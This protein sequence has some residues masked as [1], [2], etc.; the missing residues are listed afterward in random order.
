MYTN[1]ELEQ[2]RSQIS[3]RWAVLLLPCLLCLFLIVLGFIRRGM[4]L[5]ADYD[6]DVSS[7]EL[8][9][10]VS[11]AVLGCLLISGWDLCIKPLRRYEVHMNA[12]LNGITHKVECQFRSVDQETSTVDGVVFYT[13]NVVCVDDEGEPYDRIFYW[14]AEKALPHWPEGQRLLVTFHDR[15]LAAVEAL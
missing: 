14:D 15:Q 13:M 11:G 9:I 5:Q 3:K 10:T 6:A 4:V 12:M 1:Q 2:L 7:L 8:L